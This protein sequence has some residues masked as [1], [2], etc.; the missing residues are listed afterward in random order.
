MIFRIEEQ[1]SGSPCIERIWQAQTES[2][3]TFISRAAIHCEMVVTKYS[4]KIM[5]TVRGPETK[6]R[7]LPVQQQGA[8]FFGITF[9]L[10][11]FM[12]QLPP[13]ILLDGRDANLAEASNQSFWLDS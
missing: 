8:E 1:P 5:V 13:K 7:P 9:K 6:A 11:T 2:A 10:G 12:P 3:G 4:G